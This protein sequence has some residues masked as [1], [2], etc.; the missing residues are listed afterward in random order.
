MSLISSVEVLFNDCKK[1]NSKWNGKLKFTLD[2]L[3]YECSYDGYSDVKPGMRA[4]IT[5]SKTGDRVKL[6]NPPIECP[7]DDYESVLQCLVN[8]SSKVCNSIISGL[9]EQ[10]KTKRAMSRIY[11]TNKI[12]IEQGAVILECLSSND[13]E[14][15]IALYMDRWC[16]SPT[17]ISG[18][19]GDYTALAEVW[20]ERRVLSKYKLLGINTS[21]LPKQATIDLLDVIKRNPY[22]IGS[23]LSDCDVLM[24]RWNGSLNPTLR[25]ARMMFNS[26]NGE[27]KTNSSCM[28]IVGMVVSKESIDVLRTDYE[29]VSIPIG[30]RVHTPSIQAEWED[31][32][33]CLDIIKPEGL[34][35]SMITTSRNLDIECSIYWLLSHL[36]SSTF[37]QEMP[38]FFVPEDFGLDDTQLSCIRSIVHTPVSIVSGPAGV[39]KTRLIKEVVDHYTSNGCKVLV[40][41]LTGKAAKSLR[42][43]V[44]IGMTV[45]KALS[46]HNTIDCMIFDEMSMLPADLLYEFFLTHKVKS[47]LMVGDH[48]QLHPVSGVPIFKDLIDSGSIETHELTKVYRTEYKSI[49]D[50]AMK[51]RS[52]RCDFTFDS[53]FIIDTRPIEEVLLDYAPPTDLNSFVILSPF[54]LV[55]EEMAK[56][57]QSLHTR[58]G[59]S[60]TIAS[61]QYF[62][63][64]RIMCL[65]NNY[66]IDVFNGEDG[67]VTKIVGNG[68]LVE[69]DGGNNKVGIFSIQ[70]E[71]D[72]IA[73]LRH[74][75]GK[76]GN[77][78]AGSLF[79]SSI[80]YSM[81]NKVLSS[82]PSDVADS[83]RKMVK[84]NGTGKRFTLGYGCTVHKYEGAQID[85]VIFYTG[86]KKSGPNLLNS[87]MLYVAATR[88]IKSFR[89]VGEEIDMKI[90]ATTP[91]PDYLSCYKKKKECDRELDPLA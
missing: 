53:N 69:Y 24:K 60:V 80:N 19:G 13:T 39:G 8:Y 18:Y 59:K 65:V 87:S 37:N 23:P 71:S 46:Y 55:A 10:E 32:P 84:S 38:D 62:L 50:N 61:D 54:R 57:V 49:M 76:S 6:L 12:S 58:K 29:V 15:N 33:E 83:Y 3:R 85:H 78:I 66:P 67:I 56:R 82:V 30:S 79:M 48:Y 51:I 35:D 68:M 27:L 81:R 73:A 25:E 86:G 26:L 16:T 42:D 7:G 31:R 52:L 4:S 11:S 21:L 47:V 43:K 20:Y 91:P 64:D 77:Y 36:N 90:M 14:N 9:P 44:G 2:N 72:L 41:S 70:D 22:V 17:P 1:V 75:S 89:F 40:A 34:S 74:Y 28:S 88:A 45:H 63:G 5:Y